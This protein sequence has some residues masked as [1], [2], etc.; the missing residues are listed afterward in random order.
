MYRF[1]QDY[2]LHDPSDTATWRGC[3]L[4]DDNYIVC[5]VW[6]NGDGGGNFYV[7]HNGE[8]RWG[9]EEEAIAKYTGEDAEQSSIARELGDLAPMDAWI[10]ELKNGA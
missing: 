6:S 3:V 5:E 9:I 1:E 2:T 4:D 8:A 7:W 10:E